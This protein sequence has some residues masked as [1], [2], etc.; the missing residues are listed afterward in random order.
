MLGPEPQ[1]LQE[2]PEPEQLQAEQPRQEE[3]EPEPEPELEREREPQT[4][5][6]LACTPA[7]LLAYFFK[8]YKTVDN[9]QSR[10][11]Y[12]PAKDPQAVYFCA[13]KPGC[14][15]AY[16]STVGVRARTTCWRA[17]RRPELRRETRDRGDM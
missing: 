11:V 10:M 2:Q 15:V 5:R 9:P 12:G 8:T 17:G 6:K 16:C 7:P 13:R 1:Q 14:D 4:G 3:P